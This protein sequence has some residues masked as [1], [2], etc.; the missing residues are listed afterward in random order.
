MPSPEPLLVYQL[1]DRTPRAG[2][3]Y[4]RDDDASPLVVHRAA[5]ADSVLPRRAVVPVENYLDGAVARV[6]ILLT[7]KPPAWASSDKIRAAL[8]PP[9]PAPS[10][11]ED[12]ETV[13]AWVGYSATPCAESHAKTVAALAALDRLAAHVGG[14]A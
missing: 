5:S 12:V 10:L 1:L 14:G 13:R 4:V 3:M 8:L 9:A 11:A 2:E 6:R 7:L